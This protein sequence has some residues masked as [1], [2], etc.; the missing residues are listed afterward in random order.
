M[1]TEQVAIER[2]RQQVAEMYAR[3][4]TQG[5]IARHLGV[6]QSTVSRDLEEIRA[7]WRVSR[8]KAFEDRVLDELARLDALERTYW[9]AWERST[10]DAETRTAKTVETDWPGKA[11][12]RDKASR[13]EASKREVGKVGD[14]RYLDGV[15]RCINRRI[16]LLGLDAPKRL[17]VT[18][19][20]EIIGIEIVRPDDDDQQT[21]AARPDGD[22]GR[23][24]EIP[25]PRGPVEG[26]GEQS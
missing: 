14:P 12:N 2:R 7:E 22:S 4:M 20:G 9:L 24:A 8:P 16:E 11:G 18:S 3:A 6:H 13:K 5:D 26:L 15:Y 21:P 23:P 25:L 1:F 19:G 10:K 17:D